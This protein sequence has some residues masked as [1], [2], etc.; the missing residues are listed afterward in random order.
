MQEKQ[1]NSLKIQD[2]FKLMVDKKAS[3]LHLSVSAPPAIRIHGKIVKVKI[4]PLDESDVRHMVYQVLSSQQKEQLEQERE[5][6]LSFG[7]KG[8]A[9]FRANIFYSKKNLSAVFR[10][11]PTVI[12]E[13]GQLNLPKTLIDMTK[14]L[15]GLILVTGPTGSGKTTTL[16]SLIDKLNSEKEGH[17]ITLEDPVEFIYQHKKCVINQ[18]E[19]GSD[20]ISFKAGIK[21]LLR[22]DPDIVL[23]GE[24]RDSETIQAALTIAET[25]HLVFGTLHTNSC[26]DTINR[27]I[28]V[29][30][31]YQQDQVRTMMS[32]VLRGVISQQL[33][34]KINS[35]GRCMAIEILIPNAAV[36]NLIRE[37]KVHQIYSQIQAGQDKTG[38]ITMN[39]SLKKHVDRGNIDL[40]SA[41][42]Y[43]TR[44]DEL[45][46]ML[47]IVRKGA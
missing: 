9:R 38:M 10:L 43:S 12:P 37:D 36:K 14:Y 35:D 6:D 17:I 26:V 33:I 15:N 24:L 22:Q 4:P 18:R 41:I 19:I 42:D 32:F 8:L 40:E 7:V 23:V 11:I 34:K 25:G 31:A 30:P 21:S 16:A 44:P 39:Q 28:N 2:L 47:G 20:T 46:K 29:F 5:L 1:E 45:M 3:D 13:F 27:I